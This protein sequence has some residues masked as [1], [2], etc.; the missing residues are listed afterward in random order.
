MEGTTGIV[1]EQVFLVPS[2]SAR[3]WETKRNGKSEGGLGMLPETA[4]PVCVLFCQCHIHPTSSGNSTLI[5]FLGLP[6][7]P[8]TLSSVHMI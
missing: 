5:F 8:I 6:C 4:V 3:H 2:L 7:H 1:T